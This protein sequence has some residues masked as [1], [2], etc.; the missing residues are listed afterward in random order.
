MILRRSVKGVINHVAD[1]L[2]FGRDPNEDTD[3]YKAHA[4]HISIYFNSNNHNLDKNIHDLTDLGD[5][6]LCHIFRCGSKHKLYLLIMYKI[7]RL[8]DYIHISLHYC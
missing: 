1:S 2:S 3:L 8:S 7:I 4:I 6:F 5:G